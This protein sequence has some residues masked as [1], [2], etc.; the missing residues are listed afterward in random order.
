MSRCLIFAN[1]TLPDLDAARRLL[2]PDDLLIAADGGTRHILDLGWTPSIII[3]DLDSATFDLRPLTDAGTQIIQ[4]PRDKNETDLELALD[5]AVGLGCHEIV[6]LAALGGRLDQT[7]GNIAILS[8]ERLS[9]FDLR[10]D[11]GVE[12]AQFCRARS[13]VQGRRGDLV[14]LIPWGGEVTGV[15]TEGLRWP[16]SNEMLVPHKTRGISN[17]MTGD[18]AHVQIE[19]GL[20]LVIHRRLITEN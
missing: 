10:L 3:G 20:L 18:I 5:H 9:T 7:L 14:S 15:R 2:R 8:D 6:I 13:E 1:G 12:S 4:H 16:L 19:S 11:N 17:E